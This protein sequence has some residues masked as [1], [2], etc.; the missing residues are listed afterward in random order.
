MRWRSRRHM[1]AAAAVVPSGLIL[2][3]SLAAECRQGPD[4][5]WRPGQLGV[6]TQS[7]GRSGEYHRVRRRPVAM[8]RR[9]SGRRRGTSPVRRLGCRSLRRH[10]CRCRAPAWPISL[11]RP[12]VRGMAA[13]GGVIAARGEDAASGSLGSEVL[14][15]EASDADGVHSGPPAARTGVGGHRLKQLLDAGPAR[16]GG[17]RPRHSRSAYWSPVPD[18]SKISLGSGVNCSWYPPT[19]SRFPSSQDASCA[20]SARALSR[21]SPLARGRTSAARPV[22]RSARH[23]PACPPAHGPGR[24]GRR[25]PTR[26]APTARRSA[27]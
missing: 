13:G 11:V 19:S 15:S 9:A 12:G 17:T 25:A 5:V 1:P 14:S 16:S 20:A 21:A 4:L 7:F 3:C 8:A 10:W 2:R 18:R 27:S 6:C 24:N 26:C 23:D 22:R